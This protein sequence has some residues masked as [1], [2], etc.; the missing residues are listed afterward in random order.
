ME[1]AFSHIDGMR[2]EKHPE[3]NAAKKAFSHMYGDNYKAPRTR[4]KGVK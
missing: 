1:A 2:D 4:N 3:L